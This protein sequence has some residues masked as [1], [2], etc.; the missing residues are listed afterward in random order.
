MKA[1]QTGVSYGMGVH[2]LARGLDRHPLIGSEVII[3][4]QQRYPVFWRWRAKMLQRAMLQRSIMSEYDGWP[5][6]ISHTPNK[7]TLFNFP[8]Q[9][10]GAKM[11]RTAANRLCDADLV[12]S[13]LVHD[14]ILFELD[15]DEQAQHAVEIMRGAG[16]DV[17]GGFEIGVDVDQRLINGARYR[18]KRPL[19]VSM[20]NAVMQVLQEIG[21]LPKTA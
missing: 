8:V 1:L 12:P 2:S 6:W 3:R 9:S 5:L 20:W 7:R 21:A 10:G 4:H 15:T 19:A 18:D 16:R 17:C 11:L 14:G 13:M